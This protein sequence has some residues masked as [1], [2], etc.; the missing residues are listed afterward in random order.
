MVWLRPIMPLNSQKTSH[1]SLVDTWKITLGIHPNTH[2]PWRQE[3]S[4]HRTLSKAGDPWKGCDPPSPWANPLGFH[5]VEKGQWGASHCSP[6][7]WCPG[8]TQ[9]TFWGFSAD[10][11]VLEDNSRITIPLTIKLQYALLQR[12]S[13]T[14]L[15]N[16]GPLARNFA[17][18]QHGG[19]G[20]DLR[21]MKWNACVNKGSAETNVL[22]SVQAT[23]WSLF[24]E[25][26][27]HWD[28]LE[29]SSVLLQ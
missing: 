24:Q 29:D 26:C 15:D 19:G 23:C 25:T 17:R 5:L 8:I 6:K 21:L 4:C 11:W 2:V 22:V 12:N 9:I 14:T 20:C 7:C 27:W 18:F 3:G 28:L 13:C 10:G 1:P 16:G